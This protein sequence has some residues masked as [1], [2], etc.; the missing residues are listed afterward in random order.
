VHLVERGGAD[1]VRD[2]VAHAAREEHRLLVRVR[3]R[4]R[5]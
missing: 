5:V 3:V 1:A 2:V 4:V